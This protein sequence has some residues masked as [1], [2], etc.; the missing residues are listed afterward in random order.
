MCSETNTPR[1]RSETSTLGVKKILSFLFLS[2]LFLSFSS[3]FAT[4]ELRG[5]DIAG[6]LQ[7]CAPSGSITSDSDYKIT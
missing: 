2:L 3:V 7:G 4:C 1:V 5:D 6:S